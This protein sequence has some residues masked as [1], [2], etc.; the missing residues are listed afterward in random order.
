MSEDFL[1]ITFYSYSGAHQEEPKDQP[2]QV[3]GPMHEIPLHALA[4]GRRQGRKA[5]AESTTWYVEYYGASAM[6][7]WNRLG[8][9]SGTEANACV[10]GL[11]VTEVGKKNKKGKRTA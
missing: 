1:L 10:I 4:Q 3:Q 5:E 9:S 11:T 8:M 7:I 2:D 6:W